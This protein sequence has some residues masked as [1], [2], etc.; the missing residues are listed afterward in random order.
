MVTSRARISLALKRSKFLSENLDDFN[1][2]HLGVIF[3]DKSFIK[4][5]S[6]NSS[7]GDLVDTHGLENLIDVP[8]GKGLQVLI[9]LYILLIKPF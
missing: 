9:N 4:I 3:Y 2:H 7:H 8:T 6:F 5:T 1:H